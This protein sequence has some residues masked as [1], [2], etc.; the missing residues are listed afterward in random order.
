VMP[1]TG[2]NARTAPGRNA[3]LRAWNWR[4]R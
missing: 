2:L 4:I 3:A 1:I